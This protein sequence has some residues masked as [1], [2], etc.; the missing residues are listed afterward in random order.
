M[1]RTPFE[2]DLHG[3]HVSLLPERALFWP[4]A[5]T[6]FITDV[7]LGKAATFR[8]AAISIPG[9]GTEDDLARLDRIIVQT[10]A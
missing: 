8:A 6:L 3:E 1:T 7:H 10:Q 4:R 2:T 9:G 5:A